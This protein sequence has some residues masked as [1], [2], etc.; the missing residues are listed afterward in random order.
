MDL[1]LIFRREDT[2]PPRVGVAPGG[3]HLEAG[4]QLGAAGVRHHQSHFAG[5]LRAGVVRKIFTVQQ[6]SAPLGGQ[7]RCQRLEQGGFSRAV[8]A[9]EG[10]DAPLPDAEADVL[11]QGRFAVADGKVLGAAVEF[12]IAHSRPSCVWRRT[13]SQMTTGAPKTAVTE[14]M[15][16]SVGANRLR[17]MRSQNRQ[18]A[19]PPRQQPGRT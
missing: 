11:H 5:A 3:R 18:N 2:Q 15:D 6:D 14:L 12:Q 16:S 10:E 13:S 9:D 8:G 4:G 19:A 1:A 17:A 7:L